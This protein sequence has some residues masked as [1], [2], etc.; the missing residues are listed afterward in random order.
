V[1]HEPCP[2]CGAARV[3]GVP[4]EAPDADPEPATCAC[5]KEGP[6][7]YPYRQVAEK[8]FELS[9]SNI[10][11]EE[12]ETLCRCGQPLVLGVRDNRDVITH[13]MPYCRAFLDLD[14]A[15]FAEWLRNEPD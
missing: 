15:A 8:V 7:H 14:F 2:F 5:G 4:E 6:P 1:S 13:K 12:E 9:R 3:Y 11:E 10:E